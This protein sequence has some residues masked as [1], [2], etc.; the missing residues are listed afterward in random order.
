MLHTC[1]RIYT[2]LW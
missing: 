1:L 2:G